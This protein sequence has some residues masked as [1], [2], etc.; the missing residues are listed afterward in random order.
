MVEV[1]V[2]DSAFSVVTSEV[3]DFKSS[4]VVTGIVVEY[5]GGT[6]VELLSDDT[7]P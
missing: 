5:V 2:V 1:N 7:S 4:G 6:G 3:D